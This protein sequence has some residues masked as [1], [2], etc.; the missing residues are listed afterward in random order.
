MYEMV[1]KYTAEYLS[2]QLKC[3]Y[4]R[5]INIQ[6][7]HTLVVQPHRTLSD[8]TCENTTFEA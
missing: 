2:V 3:V 8:F 5:H 7:S 6:V 1:Q 4:F